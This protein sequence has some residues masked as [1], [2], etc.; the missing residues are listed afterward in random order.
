MFRYVS[1]IALCTVIPM[2]QKMPMPHA[3]STTNS[4]DIYRII[5]I[6]IRLSILNPAR[7]AIFLVVS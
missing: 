7:V 2:G 5:A 6:S 3:G 4:I 1:V